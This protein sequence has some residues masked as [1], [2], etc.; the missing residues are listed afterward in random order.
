[1]YAPPVSLVVFGPPPASSFSKTGVASTVAEI[2][3][4]V[5]SHHEKIYHNCKRQIK[6]LFA[7]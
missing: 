2:I 7:Y 4:R 3:R 1:M 5:Y 6:L